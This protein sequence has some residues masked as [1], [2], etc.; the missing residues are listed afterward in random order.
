ML[1]LLSCNFF[2]SILLG[3]MPHPLAVLF[4]CSFFIFLF[5]NFFFLIKKRTAIFAISSLFY[6]ANFIDTHFNF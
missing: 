1:V 2:V 5:N 3:G 6:F 4:S